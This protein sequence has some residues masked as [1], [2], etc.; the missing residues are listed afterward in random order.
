MKSRFRIKTI[1][2]MFVVAILIFVGYRSINRPVRDK[3]GPTTF[4]KQVDLTPLYRTAVH[5]DGRL[6]SFESHAKTYMGYISGP[7]TVLGQ[8]NGFTYLDLAFRPQRYVDA[9]II[10]IKN[11][12]VRAMILKSLEGHPHL[13]AERRDAIR[14]S[15]LISPMLLRQPTVTALL[16]RLGAVTDGSQT[17]FANVSS[18]VAVVGSI[19]GLGVVGVALAIRW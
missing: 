6:R 9:D 3:Q 18:Q 11:K 10:Y 12:N 14:K 2:A 8:L 19:N 13:G 7:R 1:D 15:G 4:A 5:A 17:N 16:Q